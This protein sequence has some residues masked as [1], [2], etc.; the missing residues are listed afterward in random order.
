MN[1]SAIADIGEYLKSLA[2]DAVMRNGDYPREKTAVDV[3]IILSELRTVDKVR[4]YY[5]QTNKIVS[6]R[7]K[8]QRLV[9]SR[10][11]EIEEASRKVPSLVAGS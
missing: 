3:S 11:R 6:A 9:D 4:Q 7:K 2:P 10:L 1:L 5:E 8:R